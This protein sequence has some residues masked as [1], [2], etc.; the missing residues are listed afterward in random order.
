M[1]VIQN[2]LSNKLFFRIHGQNS[3]CVHTYL[4]F[5]D[6]V[7]VMIYISPIC[8]EKLSKGFFTLLAIAHDYLVCVSRTRAMVVT[9]IVLS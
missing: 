3:K 4:L 8:G 6:K 1:Q 2:I 7:S 9:D 5:E